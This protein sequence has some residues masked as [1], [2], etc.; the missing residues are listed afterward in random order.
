MGYGQ[1]TRRRPPAAGSTATTRA[2]RTVN[3]RFPG[4]VGGTYPLL[5]NGTEATPVPK[6]VVTLT[7][8]KRMQTDGV[9]PRLRRNLHRPERPSRL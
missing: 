1:T 3:R 5:T 6:A 2:A 8:A 4:M 7:I 9:E